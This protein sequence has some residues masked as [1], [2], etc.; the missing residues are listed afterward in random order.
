MSY[1]EFVYMKIKCGSG[2]AREEAS[3]NTYFPPSDS[4]PTIGDHIVKNPD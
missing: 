2:L 1:T 3:S 4:L